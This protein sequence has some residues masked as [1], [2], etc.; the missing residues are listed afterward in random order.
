VVDLQLIE[1]IGIMDA[2]M[3]FEV[4]KDV[5][6]S[7]SHPLSVEDLDE[8]HGIKSKFPHLLSSYVSPLHVIF[9]LNGVL[10]ATHFEMIRNT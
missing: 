1:R 10:V 5:E 9:Y 3:R 8:M 7:I 6:F 2:P 4:V